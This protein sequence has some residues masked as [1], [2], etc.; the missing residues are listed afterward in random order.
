MTNPDPGR[1]EDV[2]VIGAGWAGLSAAQHLT[3]GGRQV[4]LFEMSPLPGGRARQAT[5]NLA[6]RP[7][8]L[9][10]GQ[11]LLIGGYQQT[12][13]LIRTATHGSAS[14]HG[15]PAGLIRA[16]FQF[17]SQR[18]SIRRVGPAQPG[19][20]A[21]ILSARGY[22]WGARVAIASFGARLALARWQTRTG[23]TV[24][25]LLTR[26]GQPEQAIAQLWEPMC[27]AALN[28]RIDQAC[29]QV[30]A[31]VL[32]D[33]LMASQDSSDFLIPTT[34]LGSLLPEPLLTWLAQN[35]STIHHSSPVMSICERSEP[36]HG[37][38][39][40]INIR[41]QVR[42]FR[43]IILATPIAVSARLL[44]PLAPAVATELKRFRFESI[45][46]VYL[47][48]PVDRA[49]ALAAIQMLD[50]DEQAGFP[51]QWLFSRAHQSGLAIASVVVS[52]PEVENRL[53]NN[54]LA[55]LVSEQLVR[56]LRL[57]RPVDALTITE[58]RATFR[59]TPDRPQASSTQVNGTQLPEGIW[60]AGDYCWTRYPATLES[61]VLSGRRAAGDLLSVAR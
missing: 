28:T 20:L 44:E 18:A 47:A 52:A 1:V 16:P 15:T 25:D 50:S 13:A 42:L 51:G 34:D 12:L 11:H 36:D 48:W 26:L 19:L 55:R 29:A 56:Q 23:E 24:I 39:W 30:F 8:Q 6:G 38:C 2:A 37:R 5:V 57:P 58:K 45:Q 9:D 10:N 3:A 7:V 33:T 31:N 32:H 17:S 14:Q 35:G 22:T 40:Q 27:L 21:G 46:T 54:A 43:Q 49:P 41:D 61:A 59:C 4:S 53:E 60:L